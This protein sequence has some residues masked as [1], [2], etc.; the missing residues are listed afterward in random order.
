MVTIIN[1]E[2]CAIRKDV[3]LTCCLRWLKFESCFPEDA[4]RCIDLPELRVHVDK[5]SAGL[6]CVLYRTNISVVPPNYW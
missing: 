6:V 2:F 4:A 1:P 5:E 3:L